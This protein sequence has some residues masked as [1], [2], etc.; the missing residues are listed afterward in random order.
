M[1]QGATSRSPSSRWKAPRR[2][3]FAA[4]PRPNTASSFASDLTVNPRKLFASAR[5]KAAD[6]CLFERQT[7]GDLAVRES[8]L[9][10]QQATSHRLFDFGEGAACFFD[11]LAAF[12]VFFRRIDKKAV[13]GALVILVIANHRA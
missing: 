2:N 6:V 13:G 12:E 11:C 10:E 8:L 5:H 1:K 4:C 3:S 9:F 7:G